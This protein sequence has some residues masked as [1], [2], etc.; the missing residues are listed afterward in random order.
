MTRFARLPLFPQVP[1]LIIGLIAAII[2]PLCVKR[3][4]PPPAPEARG[5]PIFLGVGGWGVGGWGGWGDPCHA[6][7]LPN[8]PTARCETPRKHAP[9]KESP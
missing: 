6:P 7:Q 8:S 5:A 3:E 2:I 4:A 9:Y 1:L